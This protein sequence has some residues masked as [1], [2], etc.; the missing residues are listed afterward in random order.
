MPTEFI[1]K[2]TP[3]T[4]PWRIAVFVLA[5]VAAN[6]LVG[7]FGFALISVTPIVQWARAAR[8]PLAPLAGVAAAILATWAAGRIGDRDAQ[9]VWRRIGL[10]PD[11]WRPKPV[12]RATIVAVLALLVPA[13]ILLVA[14]AVQFES[15]AAT[16]SWPTVAWTVLALMAPAAAAEEL[17]FRGYLFTACRDLM[18]GKRTIIAT[19][20]VFGLLHIFNAAPTVLSLT[21]VAVAGVFLGVVRLVTGSLVAAFAAHL[22]FNLT[23]AVVLHA[24]VSG[25]AIQ[26][27]GYRLVS[28]GPAWLTGGEWGP[29]GGA[30]VMVTLLAAT[31]LVGRRAARSAASSPTPPAKAP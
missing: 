19:S 11:A 10:A 21:A 23:Q 27:P 30:A 5:V 7:M 4:A 15:A 17:L 28:L 3:L 31:F 16:D 20:L 2:P 24:P 12:V 8:I 26:T 25:L 1:Q 6:V 22:A 14:G 13:G 9:G 29:E 18:G